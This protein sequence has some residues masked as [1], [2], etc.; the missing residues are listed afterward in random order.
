MEN[1]AMPGERFV[2][3]DVHKRHVVVAAVNSQQQVILAPHKISVE[4]LRPGQQPT[5]SQPTE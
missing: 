1:W 3:L 5:C 2:G 4:D